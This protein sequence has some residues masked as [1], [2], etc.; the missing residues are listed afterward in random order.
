MLLTPRSPDASVIA[1]QLLHQM[2]C[3]ASFDASTQRATAQVLNAA[4]SAFETQ[5]PNAA[6]SQHLE[7][8]A[9]KIGCG[10]GSGVAS[11][12]A[13][14]QSGGGV[15]GVS[16]R[17]TAQQVS[18]QHGHI[19]SQFGSDVAAA[20]LLNQTFRFARLAQVEPPY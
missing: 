8:R 17:S 20:V 18:A 2:S 7:A 11:A 15:G 1:S 14:D 4:S 6:T 16:R 13:K 3:P 12:A 5:V 9:P 19:G 10:G